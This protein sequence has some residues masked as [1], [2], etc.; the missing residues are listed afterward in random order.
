MNLLLVQVSP[1]VATCLPVWH[2]SQGS[3]LCVSRCLFAPEDAMVP[4]I[5]ISDMQA[6]LHSDALYYLQYCSS[7]PQQSDTC[8]VL[9]SQVYLS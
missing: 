7:D 4:M 1:W 3:K 8:H 9:P 5:A 6:C 2:N